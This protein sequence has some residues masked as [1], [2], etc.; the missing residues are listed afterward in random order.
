MVSSVLDS[1]TPQ[2]AA[3]A[4]GNELLDITKILALKTQNALRGIV[5]QD[6]DRAAKIY[7]PRSMGAAFAEA[8][9]DL[10]GNV[11][12][13]KA[14][15]IPF[16]G[17]VLQ[18]LDEMRYQLGVSQDFQESILADKEIDALMPAITYT[19]Q[20]ETGVWRK[21]KEAS[22]SL[23]EQCCP[24]M[25]KRM[26]AHAIERY[27]ARQ[28]QMPD[29]DGS[30]PVNAGANLEIASNREAL[31]FR[32]SLTVG[33]LWEWA[34]ATQLLTPFD[35]VT[36]RKIKDFTDKF[37]VHGYAFSGKHL[38]ASEGLTQMSADKLLTVKELYQTALERYHT[39]LREKIEVVYDKYQVEGVAEYCSIKIMRSGA[40][41]VVLM[42]SAMTATS[43]S[44]EFAQES[45]LVV[46]EG[47]VVR[48]RLPVAIASAL[49][50][51]DS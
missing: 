23:Y 34:I 45:V 17:D 51:Y 50:F 30:E 20:G 49:Y 15:R 26:V 1:T 43:S 8:L 14:Y 47:Q 7:V 6:Y 46:D 13:C 32:N 39:Q 42:A 16:E 12:F 29:G 38:K 21:I 4:E 27:E 31:A 41:Y 36:L 5:S 35:G 33:A 3:S 19:N 9:Q 22:P 2:T 28:A 44:D 40:T 10:Y 37:Q 25:S 18:M 24:E 48:H 11:N